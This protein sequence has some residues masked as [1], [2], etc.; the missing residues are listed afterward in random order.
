MPSG[1]NIKT[2]IK[3]INPEIPL[4]PSGIKIPAKFSVRPIIIPPTI[5]PGILVKPPNM[6]AGKA[7]SPMKPI[8]G[9]K[10]ITGA[11]RI[12]AIAAIMEAIIQVI[13]IMFSTFIPM[14]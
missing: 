10:K 1:L 12:P 4:N 7:F 11:T 5:A 3:M 14:R 6:A 8:L 9:L 2:I 13:E